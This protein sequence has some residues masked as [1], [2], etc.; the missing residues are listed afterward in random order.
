MV[1]A[2][3]D[4]TI[5]DAIAS[6]DS[7]RCPAVFPP[8][9]QVDGVNDV[10]FAIA[11]KS[12]ELGAGINNTRRTVGLILVVGNLVLH[13]VRDGFVVDV[14]ISAQVSARSVDSHNV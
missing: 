3:V 5:V 9:D 11:F 4:L 13:A 7:K 1:I 10:I 8:T 14:A 2:A 6:S 12:L